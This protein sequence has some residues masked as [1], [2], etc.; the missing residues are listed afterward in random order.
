LIANNENTK[1]ILRRRRKGLLVGIG[2][3]HTILSTISDSMYYVVVVEH[4]WLQ[5]P[6]QTVE[7]HIL[8]SKADLASRCYQHPPVPTWHILPLTLNFPALGLGCPAPRGS[9]LYNQTFW[10][11][12]PCF[13]S[14]CMSSFSLS[15]PTASPLCL[16]SYG[17]FPGLLPWDQ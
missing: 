15:L 9:S 16:P 13:P 7:V 3:G 11:T 14:L 5:M 6:E 10:T 4:V 17:K 1:V 12:L 8:H 2:H